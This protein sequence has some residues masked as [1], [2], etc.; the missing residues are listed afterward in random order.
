MILGMRR[1]VERRV[2]SLVY[3][4][5]GHISVHQRLDPSSSYEYLIS[6]FLLIWD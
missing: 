2:F 1:R 3:Q 5:Y 4:W 6:F